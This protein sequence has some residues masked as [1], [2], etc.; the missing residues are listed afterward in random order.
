MACSPYS[1]IH[2]EPPAQGWN[3]PWRTRL[4]H[5]SPIINQENAPPN[6]STGQFSTEVASFQMILAC[7][8]LKKKNLTRTLLALI[9]IPKHPPPQT[10]IPTISS[11]LLHTAPSTL[12]AVVGTPPFPACPGSSYS[13]IKTSLVRPRFCF[14]HWE[15]P[16][17]SVVY[18]LME[19]QLNHGIVKGCDIGADSSLVNTGR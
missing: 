17:L 9:E 19:S 8:K 6:L 14:K 4:F 3:H 11:P 12:P 1:L 13:P 7:V 2:P 18:G 15:P 5:T 10:Q 16:E